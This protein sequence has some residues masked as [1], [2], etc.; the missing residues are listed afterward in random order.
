LIE[1]PNSTKLKGADLRMQKTMGFLAALLHD[2]E[3]D[4]D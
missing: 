1:D 2:D 3:D 4:K